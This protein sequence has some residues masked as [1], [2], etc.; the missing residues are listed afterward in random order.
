MNK[1]K[2][3]ILGIILS[4]LLGVIGFSFAYFVA[5]VSIDGNNSAITEMEPSK[6]TKVTYDAGTSALDITNAI[7]GTISNKDFTININPPKADTVTYA[8][9]IKINNNSFTVCNDSTYVV[10]TNECDKTVEEL[11]YTLKEGDTVIGTGSLAGVTSDVELA[12]LTKNVSLNTTYNY[13]LIIDFKR[14][15]ADQNHNANKSL[16]GNIEVQFAK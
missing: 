14:T 4:G 12:K 1:E 2:W 13:S 9:K 8:I 3:I 15:N 10:G 11:V 5:G 7:P 6:Y 16:T